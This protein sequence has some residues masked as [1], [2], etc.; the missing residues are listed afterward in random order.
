MILATLPV[1]KDSLVGP[2]EPWRTAR[3]RTFDLPECACSPIALGVRLFAE[4]GIRAYP[5]GNL[6]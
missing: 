1:F 5:K 6:P 4:Q 2:R 3:Y